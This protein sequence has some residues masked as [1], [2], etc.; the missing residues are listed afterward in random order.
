MRLICPGAEPCGVACLPDHALLVNTDGF[1]T[2]LPSSGRE[3]WGMVWRLTEKDLHR[4]DVREGVGDGLFQRACLPVYTLD[5][6][7]IEAWLHI[8]AN[9]T[10]GRPWPGYLNRICSAAGEWGLPA[11]YLDMLQQMREQVSA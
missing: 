4:L 7:S 9:T 1:A 3:V 11:S 2:P 10:P 8:S 5:G 6:A